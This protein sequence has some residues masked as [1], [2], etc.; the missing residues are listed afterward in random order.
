MTHS[1]STQDTSNIPAPSDTSKT[2]QT[3]SDASTPKSL[4][5]PAPSFVKLAM[6]NMVRKGGKSVFHFFLT[7]FGLLAILVSL[8]YLTR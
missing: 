4:S 1:S 6:R 7:A 5:E 8:A 2:H 3:E